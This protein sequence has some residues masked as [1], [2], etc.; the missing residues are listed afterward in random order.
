MNERKRKIKKRKRQKRKGRKIILIN[1]I[2]KDIQENEHE[3]I[4]LLYQLARKG[5]EKMT[6]KELKNILN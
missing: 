3:S 5:L 2:L 4:E 6:E 1:N